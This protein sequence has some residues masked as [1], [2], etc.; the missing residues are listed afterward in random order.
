MALWQGARRP[1]AT[2]VRN[3]GFMV[4]FAFGLWGMMG[5]SAALAAAAG[6]SA[7][8]IAPAHG[9][10][11]ATISVAGT[12]FGAS[13]LVTLYWNCST[14]PC[15]GA[16]VLGSTTTDATG[17]FAGLSA[18]I[19]AAAAGK[20]HIAGLGAT[21]GDFA[22]KSFTVT[23]AKAA[24]T[25]APTHGAPGTAATVSGLGFKATETVTFYWNCPTSACTSTTVLGSTT[26]DATGAFSA[27]AVTIPATATFGK[28]VIGAKGAGGD[29]AG[30]SFTVS[31]TPTV[32]A[33]PARVTSGGQLTLSGTGFGPGELVTFYWNCNVK[34]CTGATALG[35]VTTDATGAFSGVVVTI[36]TATVGSTY[37]IGAKG[38]TTGAFA[39]ADV[40]II[41]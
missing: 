21:S 27:V 5:L 15:T 36:P 19:P 7:L 23:A 40:K 26:S 32:T 30:K 38:G 34:T 12:S 16:M 20:Y 18:K 9:L 22:I 17:A 1:L 33:T 10:A 4:M 41:A 6:K 39:V 25:V 13:E 31:L 8:T 11:G 28:Y 3:A 2:S 14:S 37:A 35:S 24:L 29:F